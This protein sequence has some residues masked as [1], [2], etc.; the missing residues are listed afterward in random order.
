[1][2]VTL[3]LRNA[4]RLKRLESDR[5]L[6]VEGDVLD[7]KKLA[8]AMAGQDVVLRQP[9]RRSRTDGD[10][11]RH[12][13]AQVRSAASGLDQRNGDLR[14]GAGRAVDLDYTI[15]RPGVFTNT[16]VRRRREVGDL[17]STSI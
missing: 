7:T 15:L 14:R 10:E 11:R 17:P 9:R 2:R 3:Y 8:K 12:G 13:D 4:L 16:D 1:V 5:V 6:L